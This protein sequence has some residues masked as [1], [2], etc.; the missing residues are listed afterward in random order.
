MIYSDA[1]EYTPPN[2]GKLLW[3]ALRH[4]TETE[5]WQVPGATHT[6]AYAARP[7]EYAR[8]VIRFLDA[9]LVKKVAAQERRWCSTSPDKRMGEQQIEDEA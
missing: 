5:S 8:R 7:E 3:Q 9:H 2:D 6:H 1:D 4:K